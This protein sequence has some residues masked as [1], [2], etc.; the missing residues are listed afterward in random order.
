MEILQNS[1]KWN[2]MMPTNLSIEDLATQA[3]TKPE[4]FGYWGNEDMFK[5]WGF[6]GID[7]NRDSGLIAKSNYKAITSDLIKRYPEDFEIEQYSHWLCGWVDRLTCRILKNEGEVSEDNITEAFK[8]VIEW[9]E[10]LSDYPIADESNYYN[11]V[12]EAA[13]D[14]IYDMDEHLQEMVDKE[15]RSDWADCIYVA[16]ANNGFHYDPEENSPNEEDILYA[17]HTAQ[18]WN[19]NKVEEWKEFIDRNNLEMFSYIVENPNQLK[20]F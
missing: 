8:K 15:I 6:T 1:K 20:L 11:I 14:E 5:T 16:L 4:D 10:Q 13:I 12:Y 7:Q 9:H 17:I 19:K 3:L 18:L 2:Y